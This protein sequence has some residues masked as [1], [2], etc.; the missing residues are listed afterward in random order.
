M[1]VLLIA[2]PDPDLREALSRALSELGR[3][4]ES[5][6]EHETLER[7]LADHPALLILDLALPGADRLL[8]SLRER[9]PGLKTLLAAGDREREAAEA[10]LVEGRAAGFVPK[11]CD[12][13]ETRAEAAALL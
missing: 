4:E 6:T 10:A 2:S 5:V 8:I 1:P 12:P 3:T 7:C 11:P 13:D 9:D